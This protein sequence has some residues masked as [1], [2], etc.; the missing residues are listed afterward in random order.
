MIE[1]GFNQ[2]GRG[3]A[4]SLLRCAHQRAHLIGGS[5]SKVQSIWKCMESKNILP[6]NSTTVQANCAQIS[7]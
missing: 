1:K 6:F 5:D 3:P 2:A 4:S 7:K